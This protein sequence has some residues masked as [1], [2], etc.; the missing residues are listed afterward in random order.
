MG[1]VKKQVYKNAFISYAG[2]VIG[3]VNLV[4]LY[5]LF[6]ST[7]QLGLYILLISLSVLYS[8]IA[9]MGVPSI[10]LR[11]FPFFRTEDRKH[12]GFLWWVVGLSCIGFLIATVIYVV[13]RPF[14]VSL[15]IE[16]S[17]L[18]VDYFYVLIPLAGFTI[19]YNV[20]EAFGKA[21]YQSV[22]SS[23][24]REIALKILTTAAILVFAKGWI[25]FEQFIM[26]YVCFSG[27]ISI[28]LLISLIVSK[29]FSFGFN[30]A[31]FQS[32]KKSEVINYGLFTLLSS[33]V[34]I[35]FQRIDVLML[36]AM[37]GLAITGVY[38]FYLN[39]G[40]VI[41]I[42]AGALGRT[43][44]QLVADAWKSK[45]M[46]SIAD[47][48]YKTSIIQMVVGCLLFI[49]VIINRNNL[50]A[51]IHKKEFIDQFDLFI[52]IGLSYLVDITGGL[53]TYIITTSHK[54]R[55]VTIIVA[56]TCVFCIGLTYILIPIY[57]GMGAALAYL[58]TITG[59][60]F[61]NW[62]YL[63][64]R[65]NMQPFSYKHLIVVAITIAS[66]FLGEHF[67]R[68]PNTYLDIVVRSGVTTVFYT[69]LCYYFNVSVDL[70][71][72]VHTTLLKLGLKK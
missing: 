3:Y 7:K 29:R 48:Y 69:A 64:H 50:F 63:K 62:F 66:Y 13:A 1:I 55:M 58:I 61:F 18:Y 51:I 15:Y 56:L 49:G 8:L 11:Y 12:N 39:I 52:V 54:Y 53:N 26:L 19:L 5:P 25:T 59:F 23:F 44:Y 70:N 30:K 21:I 40:M 45:N 9:S 57:G 27:V 31:N 36:G 24:L 20:L 17:A 60:N 72:K 42:P 32:V 34:L 46:Q 37:S 2:M 14:I 67:W 71:E 47:I 35:L 16:K 65:F 33:S 22:F 6:L 4:L 41:N 10:I 43:T 38:G 68:M 28:G